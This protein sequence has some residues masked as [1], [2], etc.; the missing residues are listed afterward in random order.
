M[1]NEHSVKN[2]KQKILLIADDIHNF[3]LLLRR[4]MQRFYK[5]LKGLRFQL[6]I[7]CFIVAVIRD[8]R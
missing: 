1:H 8:F 5:E 4:I 3:P 7:Q 6:E 2:F